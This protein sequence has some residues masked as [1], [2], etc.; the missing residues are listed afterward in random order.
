VVEY[1]RKL[2][3]TAAT[4]ASLLRMRLHVFLQCSKTL[5]MLLRSSYSLNDDVGITERS[6]LLEELTPRP[7][8]RVPHAPRRILHFKLRFQH[9]HP[10]LSR[11]GLPQDRICFD[12]DISL[13]RPETLVSNLMSSYW[14]FKCGA[15]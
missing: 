4:M 14:R 11:R 10:R 3:R 8:I 13:L 5:P 9:I 1:P 15:L 7:R 2:E 6:D 12:Q